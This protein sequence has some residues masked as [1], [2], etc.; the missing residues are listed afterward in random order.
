[1]LRRLLCLLGIH[2]QYFVTD[3]FWVNKDMEAA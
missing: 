1:M 3:D 2:T